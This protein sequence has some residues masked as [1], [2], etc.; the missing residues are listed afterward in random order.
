MALK[1]TILGWLR[2]APG[3]SDELEDAEIDEVSK[4]YSAQRA[5]DIVD[6]RFGASSGE[7]ESDQEAP[8]R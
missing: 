6:K 8:G 5:D 3:K 7:F 1:Q 4:E 2:R